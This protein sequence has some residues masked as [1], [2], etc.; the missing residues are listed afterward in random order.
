M[1]QSY[2]KLNILIV[3]VMRHWGG[4]GGEILK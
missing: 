1:L 2:G 4:V 3:K